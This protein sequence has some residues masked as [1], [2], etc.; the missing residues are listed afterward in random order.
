MH[1]SGRKLCK[2]ERE[3]TSSRRRIGAS[4]IDHAERL[5]LTK[6]LNENEEYSSIQKWKEVFIVILTQ[7]AHSIERRS[8][9]FKPNQTIPCEHLPPPIP[10]SDWTRAALGSWRAMKGMR[11][12]DNVSG[13]GEENTRVCASAREFRVVYIVFVI[14]IGH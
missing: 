6:S 2:C 4:L 13:G 11:E 9:L 3:N 7:R 10:A 5:P 8:V 1:S 14:K 12:Q